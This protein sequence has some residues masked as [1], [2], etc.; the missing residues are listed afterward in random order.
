MKYISIFALVI[1]SGCYISP[2]LEEEL[3][4]M[5]LEE[6]AIKYEMMLRDLH[7]NDLEKTSK[8]KAAV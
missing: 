7:H 3:E 6:D 5:R 8:K 2:F 1:L 4:Q